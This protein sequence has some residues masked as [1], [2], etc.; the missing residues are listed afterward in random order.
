VRPCTI[1]TRGANRLTHPRRQ[2]HQD[3]F[4]E[5]KTR[6]AKKLARRAEAEAA[7]QNPSVTGGERGES[8]KKEGDDI[9]WF[10]VKVGTGDAAFGVGAGTGATT[11]VGKYLNAAKRP[12]EA[13]HVSVIPQLDDDGK[14]KRK[15]GFSKDFE[16]W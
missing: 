13:S 1:C 14:K 9:N 6:L 4:D 10:G 3:P 15:L 5:Y 8:G 2:S 16:G 11:G 12:L 7:A